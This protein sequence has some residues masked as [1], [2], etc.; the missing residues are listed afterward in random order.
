MLYHSQKIQH[1]WFFTSSLCSRQDKL[2]VINENGLSEIDLLSTT[3]LNKT[4]RGSEFLGTVTQNLLFLLLQP[5]LGCFKRLRKLKLQNHQISESFISI[6][7]Y[8]SDSRSTQG[9]CFLE[10]RAV[11]YEETKWLQHWLCKFTE[12]LKNVFL[13]NLQHL[14]NINSSTNMKLFIVLLNAE[15]RI[16]F[17]FLSCFSLS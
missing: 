13:E 6:L 11:I 1:I 9:L 15:P 10:N 12:L 14:I 2:P 17:H 5:S 7:L 3:G 16:T 4:P 8:H